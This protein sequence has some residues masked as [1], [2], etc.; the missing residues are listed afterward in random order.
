MCRSPGALARLSV[1]RLSAGPAQELKPGPV[2]RPSKISVETTNM[3]RK[4]GTNC[5]I[6][7]PSA[8]TATPNRI[9]KTIKSPM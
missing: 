5:A 8:A 4:L 6:R 3:T 7:C 2:L 9:A 1:Y